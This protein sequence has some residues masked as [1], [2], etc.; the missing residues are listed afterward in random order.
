MERPLR[1]FTDRSVNWS[2]GRSYRPE[3]SGGAPL[4]LLSSVEILPFQRV[5]DFTYFF[6]IKFIIFFLNL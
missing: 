4:D 3:E 1:K 6:K 2:G 5:L